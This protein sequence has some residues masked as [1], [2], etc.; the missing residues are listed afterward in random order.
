MT[1]L[2]PAPLTLPAL[3]FLLSL[4]LVTSACQPD[5]TAETAGTEA[6]TEGVDEGVDEGADD[7]TPA[8]SPAGGSI[9]LAAE[10]LACDS[11]AQR[12]SL[13]MDGARLP[14]LLDLFGEVSQVPVRSERDLSGTTATFQAS[15]VPWDCVLQA[16]A[17]ELDM[18]IDVRSDEIVL[19]PSS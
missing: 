11:E 6:A 3:L 10:R 16:I 19:R 17:D 15:D 5:S 12:I 1:T 14:D 13:S 4:G 18:T 9:T 7:A 2:R 8:T